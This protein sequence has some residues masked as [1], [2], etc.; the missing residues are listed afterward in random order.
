MNFINM[1]EFNTIMIEKSKPTDDR[2]HNPSINFFNGE[3]T[4]KKT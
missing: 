2:S 3:I 4:I 1:D